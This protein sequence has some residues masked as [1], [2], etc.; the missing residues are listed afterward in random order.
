MIKSQYDKI[1]EDTKNQESVYQFCQAGV[2]QVPNGYNTTI[3]AYGQTGS[4]KTYTMFG[5]N[6]ND[7][8]SGYARRRLRKSVQM[9]DF[10]HSGDKSI[11]G[12]IPRSIED[13]FEQANTVYQTEGISYNIYCSFIQIYNEKLFDLF[14]DKEAAVALNIREDKYDGV[15]IEGLSEYQVSSVQ[16]CFT[17]L[18]RGE[19]NRVTRQTKANIRSSRS[20]TIFQILLESDSINNNGKLRR[21]KL[22]LC[23]LA[24]SE[25][26]HTDERLGEKHMEEHKSINLSLSTLGKVITALAK[27][28]STSNIPYR[29]SKLTRILKDSLGGKTKTILIATCS[30]LHCHIDE[31][32]STLKFADNAKQVL[33]KASLNEVNANEDAVVKKLRRE[34]QHLKDILNMRRNKNDTDIQRELLALKEQNYRLRELASKGQQVEGLVKENQNLKKELQRYK[35]PQNSDGFLVWQ[36]NESELSAYQK[37]SS[38]TYYNAENKNDKFFM[39]EAESVL[40]NNES[41]ITESQKYVEIFGFY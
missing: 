26:I 28:S 6:W 35:A 13:L 27:N 8:Y 9:T 32:I 30:P 16:D 37:V 36:Q 18:K 41:Q 34:V 40:N 4:G 10:F 20:H 7:D 2:Y 12:I 14:Q 22:N 29:E 3:F 31:T 33:V 21:C 19:K 39:T 15:F 17:L 1:F 38:H 25:K 11:Q 24:G 5:P 23:D